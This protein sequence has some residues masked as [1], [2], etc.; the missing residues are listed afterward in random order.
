MVL[1]QSAAGFILHRQENRS[2]AQ[3]KVSKAKSGSF[4]L[5][6]MNEWNEPKML[7]KAFLTV[8]A[9]SLFSLLT[10]VNAR[11]HDYSRLG[12]SHCLA[13]STGTALS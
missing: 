1:S 5:R 2:E 9:A 10:V 8:C 13:E 4:R 3:L 11:H 7:F 12:W 6:S